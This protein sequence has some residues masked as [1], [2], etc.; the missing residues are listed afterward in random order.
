MLALALLMGGGEH[1]DHT[2]GEKF[3]LKEEIKILYK[4]K[5]K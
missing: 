1:H 5:R 2:H 4:K 3:N